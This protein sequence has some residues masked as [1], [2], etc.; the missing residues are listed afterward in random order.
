MVILSYRVSS[1]SVWDMRDTVSKKKG[2]EVWS[3]LA[4]DKE[5][6]K[7]FESQNLNQGLIFKI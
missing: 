1:R 7:I 4:W 6:N 2:E 3:K 5:W